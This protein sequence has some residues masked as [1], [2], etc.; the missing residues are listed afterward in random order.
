MVDEIYG[1]TETNNEMSKFPKD[2][3]VAMA[4]VPFQND[5]TLYSNEQGFAYGSM[6]K[7]LNKPF[8]GSD[9]KND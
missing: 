6:F 1:L 3:S 7:A 8:K 2:V 4:Y 5:N 9:I